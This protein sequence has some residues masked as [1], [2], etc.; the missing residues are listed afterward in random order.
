[1]KKFLFLLLIL[2]GA[3]YWGFSSG[4]ELTK[5]VVHEPVRPHA[6]QKS[7]PKDTPPAEEKG[8]L[9]EI[10][11]TVKTLISGLSSSETQEGS[12]EARPPKPDAKSPVDGSEKL[13]TAK[14]KM[15][16]VLHFREALEAR[17]HRE[18]F[19]PFAEIPDY[20]KKGIVATEDRRFYEHGAMDL[21]G[22]AR[23]AFTNYL[24]GE[25][26]QGGSTITQ[27]TVK[28]IF[29]SNDRTMT[30]KIEELALAVQLERNYSKEE[31]LELY[32]NTIYYGH[33]AYGLKEASRTY[34]GKAP[35]ELDLAQ[36]AMLAG[37]P[38]A[39]SAYDPISHPKEGAK[40]MTVVLALM[41]EQ[42]VITPT[43]AASAAAELWL[44]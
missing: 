38:Q 31:I 18:E 17:V 32:L 22:V 21:I 6:V 14:E 1:M 23:A 9:T 27:Q 2:G 10:S 35:K 25:T 11:D 34:F 40:R 8:I 37:L 16:N 3:M 20:L 33:G 13:L 4:N 15:D 7:P 41:A 19:V 30:R 26:L 12:I 36:C 5:N 44:K 29:L 24:A 28:N 43:Q 42:G 39:P